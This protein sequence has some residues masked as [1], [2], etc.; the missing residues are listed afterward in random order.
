VLVPNSTYQVVGRP[1]GSTVPAS[2]AEVAVTFDA[3][4]VTATGPD[5]VVKMP[6]PPRLVPDPFVATS[7]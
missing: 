7:R 3:E 4:P 1:F 2:V 5:A 6:S